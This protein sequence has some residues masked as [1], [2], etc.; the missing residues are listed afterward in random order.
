VRLV[1]LAASLFVCA[2]CSTISGVRVH[3]RVPG[4]QPRLG[5]VPRDT[6]G[7]GLSTPGGAALTTGR[8]HSAAFETRR[9]CRGGAWPSGWIAIAYESSSNECPRSTDRES[10]NVATIARYETQSIGQTLEVCADQSV[11][12]GWTIEP[13]D[14]VRGD[15]C[16]GAGKDGA[17]ATRLIRRVF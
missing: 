3:G 11:P 9:I 12:H 8:T 5:G 4:D 2:A 10:Y 16:P 13:N 17:S 1:S 7:V 14:E 6:S 15:A